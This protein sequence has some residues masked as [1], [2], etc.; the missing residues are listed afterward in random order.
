MT[1]TKINYS[2]SRE[3]YNSETGLKRWRKIGLEGEVAET[4]DTQK[5]FEHAKTIVENWHNSTSPPP[6][7][8]TD[9]SEGVETLIREIEACTEIDQVNSFGVQVGLSAFRKKADNDER[10]MDAYRKKF[11]ELVNR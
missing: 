9:T 2:E 5:A 10:A 11:N 7:P 3:T 1:I 4:D 6:P 8:S